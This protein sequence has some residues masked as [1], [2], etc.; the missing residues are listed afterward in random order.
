MSLAKRAIQGFSIIFLMNILSN[1][2]GYFIRVILAREMT[3]AEYGFFYSVF[4]FVMFFFFIRDLGLDQA[5]VKFIA[6][7][8]VK[9]KFGDIKS[10]IIASFMYRML[11]SGMISLLLII[12][13]GFLATNYFHDPRARTLLFILVLYL[14]SSPAF[15][16][17]KNMLRGFQRFS[18]FSIIEFTKNMLVIAGVAIGIYALDVKTFMTPAIA[19]VSAS[20][21]MFVILLPFALR[22]FPFFKT[23]R[24]NIS[25][26]TRRLFAFGLPVMFTGIGSKIIGYI[27][28]M[29]LTYY[30]TY[31]MIGVYNVILPSAL[32]FL[33]FGS[34]V[35]NVAFPIVSELWARKDKKTLAE[36]LRLIHKYSFVVTIPLVL[37]IFIFADI[38]IDLFFGPEYAI[39]AD[40]MRILLVGVLFYIVAIINNN[41]ISAIGK[42][43]TVTKI[44][45]SAAGVNI[46]ANL[47][48][49][50]W[51]DIHGAALATALSYLTVL[52]ASTIM[53]IRYIKSAH[54]VMVWLKVS[55]AGVVFVTIV[56]LM[57]SILETNPWIELFISC[58]VAGLVYLV[59]L[60]LTRQ[61]DIKEVRG[62]LI[63]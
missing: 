30:S 4:T 13:S 47:L 22:T 39:G 42:P 45:L 10:I 19:Y 57:K 12:S 49:I 28:T 53:V 16:V 8:N 35:S 51:F 23:K 41:F 6:E 32:L 2:V 9:K 24:T 44:I 40:P 11:S 33:Y 55:A 14:L 27:D 17:L 54:P 38:F 37:S 25:K 7:L 63:R 31:D 50:P 5:A 34:A 59:I 1:F 20:I 58:S 36:G 29:V 3:R 15:I 26:N 21:L 62:I 18:V 52:V 43:A 61:I 60:Y 56:Y 48:L 46:M